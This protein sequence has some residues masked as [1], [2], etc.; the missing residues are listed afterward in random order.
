MNAHWFQKQGYEKVDQIDWFVLLWKY[1]NK[2]AVPPEWIKGE[3]KQELIPG[4]VKVTAFFSGQCC[5]ENSVYFSA[6]KA[7]SEFT[8]KVVFEEIDMSKY[9]NRKKY[10]FSWRLYIDG[11][12]LFTGYPP[13]Y[14]Q[15]KTKIE[16]QLTKI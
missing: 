9:Q 8:D 15:I 7:A 16:E 12:N 6:K 3:F 5:S 13:S 2:N 1:F 10:G 4:K 11:E 14:E